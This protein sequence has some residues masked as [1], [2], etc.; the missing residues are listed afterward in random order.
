MK[1]SL[2]F[3]ST[4]CCGP[5]R[6]VFLADAGMGF[7]G[8]ALG[9]LL[10]REG[11]AAT[12]THETWVPPDGAPHFAPKA[13]RVIWIF[14][15]G[16][17]SHI[18]SFDP[19]PAITRYGGKTIAETPHKDVLTAPFV[20][21]N[22]QALEAGNTRHLR[23]NLFPLQIGHR[24]RGQSGIEVSD[25]WP[26]VGDCVDDLSVIRSMWTTDND[27]GA[28]LQFHT[29]R[30]IF[31]GYLPT[32]GSWVHYGLGSLNDNLPQF[33]VL[34]EPP[35]DCCGG[36]GA[37]G[38]GYL[39]PENAGVSIEVDP[40][41]PLPFASPGPD[42]YEAEQKSE[43]ELLKRLNRLAGVEYPDDPKMR[44]RIKSY[45]LAFR[46]Q[47]AVPEA[48]SFKE[49]NEETKRLYGL[50]HE[51]TQPF[52]EVCLAARR[53]SERGVRFVQIYHG[54]SANKWDAHKALKTSY[55]DLCEKVDKPIAGLIK[56][57][58]QR[59]MLDDTLVVW[60]TEF[61]RT[62]GAEGAS[63]RDHHPYGFSIW[64]AGGGV[65]GGYVH[66]ATDELGF[67]AVENRHYV[68]DAHAT[69]LHQLGLDPRRLEVPGRKRLDIDFGN[70]IRDILI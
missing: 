44:A 6:R 38:A 61:G 36:T 35:G 59:G 54:T 51:V 55:T 27:H 28:I 8:L 52:G 41:N 57:L 65:K 22:V 49:E 32:M 31:D 12:P 42:V 56:D 69:V 15:L 11:I 37:H 3:A 64:M 26:H 43:F 70:P 23:M 24:K 21:Q 60:A 2:P 17:V 19:K 40:D 45:E 47:T 46:M 34:G 1:K 14:M 18:E 20:K 50:D 68:T 9:S 39:G 29:G 53:M 25:W 33:M 48:M 7:T 58:K 30:H 62:P 4:G 13:K 67:H 10:A 66:G 5:S 16:G 63:G